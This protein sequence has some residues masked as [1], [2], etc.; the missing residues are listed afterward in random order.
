[1][2]EMTNTSFGEETVMENLPSTSEITPVVWPLTRILAPITGT[3]STSVTNPFKVLFPPEAYIHTD[4]PI[5]HSRKKYRHHFTL[6]CFIL[7]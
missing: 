5:K 2:Y 7:F 4:I 6:F 1:M 3:P